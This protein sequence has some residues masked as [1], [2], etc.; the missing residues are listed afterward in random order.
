MND[1]RFMQR[2]THQA[3][4]GLGRTAPNPP[5]GAVVLGPDGCARGVGYHRRA[6]EPHAEVVALADAGDYAR[7]GTLYCT[8]E[9]CCHHG[10]TPPCT[11]A[12]VA[13]GV[14]RVV[15]AVTDP[16]PRCAGG[17]AA[18]LRAAG[19]QVQQ[20]APPK[21]GLEALYEAY[22]CH[23]RTG[24]PF[25]TLKL[26]MSLDGKVATRTGDSR[27]VTG[28][29]ARCLVHQW[30]DEADAVLVGVGTVLCDDPQLTVRTGARDGRQPLRVVVDTTARLPLTARLLSEP[31]ACVVAVGERAEPQRL[32][33]LRGAGAEV[34]LL[35]ETAGGVDLAALLRELGARNVMGL[36]CEGGPRL[37]ASLVHHGLVSKY[38]FFL[39]PKLVG[40]EG[41]SGLG[42]LG[43]AL[44]GEAV[45]LS[46]RGTPVSYLDEDLLVTA[47]P[48]SPD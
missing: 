7:G 34:L 23:K 6:G 1:Y 9:P 35:P 36:L 29:R 42:P 13:A 15:Y 44:M 45:G 10:R 21:A 48:C 28:P 46:R 11:D 33:A 27:W 24:L 2:A 47:Y 32:A 43:L 18:A 26:A 37:A 19:L 38:Q 3:R 39:A 20:C 40:A 5:V 12:I 25:V 22:L 8:L 17:G 30:R 16:D 31:G 41:L 14:S 4:K